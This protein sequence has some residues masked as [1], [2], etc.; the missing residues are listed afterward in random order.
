MKRQKS[1]L[2]PQSAGPRA[3]HK[4][5][6]WGI[7]PEPGLQP[8]AGTSR[9]DL[10][11]KETSAGMWGGDSLQMSQGRGH[12]QAELCWVPETPHPTPAPIAKQRHRAGWSMGPGPSPGSSPGF[13]GW[14]GEV[15]FLLRN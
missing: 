4:A 5:Q 14:P 10:L 8:C 3:S 2:D 1:G 6:W 11:M 9:P 15:V 7:T 12:T 13:L